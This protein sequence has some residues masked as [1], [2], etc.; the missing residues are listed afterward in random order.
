[1]PGLDVSATDDLDH[2][3]LPA[4]ATTGANERS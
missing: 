4:W 2:F 3:L 1:V